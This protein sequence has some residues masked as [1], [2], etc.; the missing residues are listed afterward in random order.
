MNFSTARLCS[1]LGFL[2]PALLTPVQTARCYPAEVPVTVAVSERIP[3]RVIPSG[4]QGFS[5]ELSNLVPGTNGVCYF[6]P[7]NKPLLNIF[8][9]L[10]IGS[11]RI[12]GNTGDRDFKQAPSEADI[13]SLFE[14]AKQAGTKVIYCLRLLNGDPSEQTRI[15]KYIWDHYEPQLECF[16]IGQEPSAYPDE[17]LDTRRSDQ[18]MGDSNEHFKYEVF[19]ANWNR[20]NETLRKAI[21]DVRI[22]G[23]GVHRNPEWPLRFIGDFGK[24]NGVTLITAHLY[25]GGPGNKIVSTPELG[26]ERML[27]GEFEEVY[28]SLADAVIPVTETNHLGFRIEEGNN[29]YNG[30]AK[31]VSD[32]FASSLWGLDL[33]WWWASHG[34]VGFNLHTGDKVA[35]GNILT[36]C[37][38]ASFYMV[39]EGVRAQPLAYGIKAFELG[40]KGGI[41]PVRISSKVPVKLSAYAALKSDTLRVTLINR[42]HGAKAPALEVTL[43]AGKASGPAESMA[44]TAPNDDVAAKQGILLGGSEITSE[45]TWKGIWTPLPPLGNGRFRVMLSPASA[46]ILRIPLDASGGKPSVKVSSRPVPAS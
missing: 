41:V 18:R 42:E 35:A 21:P 4:F 1:L 7:D 40:A 5:Y 32:T 14:F 39:P 24:T 46:L 17:K 36:T 9:T 43:E 8:K 30:G 34:A 10:G 2:L 37:S 16:T 45:G 23:P 26:R 44:L 3:G 25:P 11:L 31:D 29:Y 22:A 20:F 13:D 33:L 12:G 28:G 27:S 19:A 38:Y 15:A 6:R